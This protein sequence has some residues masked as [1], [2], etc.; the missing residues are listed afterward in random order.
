MVDWWAD[1]GEP[2]LTPALSRTLVEGVTEELGG[3]EREVLALRDRAL[4]ELL[5]L[6]DR[7]GLPGASVAS[8][9]TGR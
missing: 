5:V 9:E 7:L 4:R 1:L 6:K 3:R 2:E 8:G